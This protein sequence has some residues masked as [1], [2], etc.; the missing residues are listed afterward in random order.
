MNT[1]ASNA[2]PPSNFPPL[3]VSVVG[4]GSYGTAMAQIAARNNNSVKL[5]ARDEK[6]VKMINDTHHNPKYLSDF[7]LLPNIQAINDVSECLKD[8][9][10]IM[11][12]LPAQKTPQFLQDHRDVIPPNAILCSTSKG[13]YVKTRQ[14]LSDAIEDALKPSKHELA[15]LSGPSFAKE[16]MQ[17]MPTLVV[18]SSKTLPPAVKIQRTLSSTSFRIYTSQDTIGVQL[19]GALKNPL[20]IGAGM[21]EGAGFGISAL[22]AY[23]TR[24]CNELRQ[25]CV[26]MGGNPETIAG[27]SG[28][29]DLMLT[30]FGNLSRN[31]SM[32]MRIIKGERVE[33][34]CKEY[35]VEGVPTSEV[36]VMFADDCGLEVPIFRAVAKIINGEVKPEDVQDLLMSRPLTTEH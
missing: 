7:E 10:V 34:I 19:G 35:T 33:D 28:V 18:V 36:A 30:A 9:D 31:R 17:N 11:L 6:Q 24:S 32:G 20:A 8:A 12:C 14:L 16:I 23:V 29:G 27:L 4:A 3:K 22:A 21:V 15:F 13:L 1:I 25:L 26:A 2:G 5:Y